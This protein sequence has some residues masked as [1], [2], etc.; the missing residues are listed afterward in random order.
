M[1][2]PRSHGA[3]ALWRKAD[4]V[5]PHKDE[6]I[7]RRAGSEPLTATITLSPEWQAPRFKLSDAGLA[8]ALVI[9]HDTKTVR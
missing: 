9:G 7:I 1:C 4:H 3:Q 2:V 6:L 8:S 5:G